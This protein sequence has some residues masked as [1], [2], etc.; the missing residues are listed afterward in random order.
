MGKLIVVAVFVVGCSWGLLHFWP[1]ASE[2]LFSI[3]SWGVTGVFVA[4][5][6]ALAFVWN[7]VK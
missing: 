6:A 3:G 2:A 4:A 1:K 5:V 7:R